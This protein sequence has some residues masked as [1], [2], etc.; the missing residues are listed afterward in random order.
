MVAA[1]RLDWTEAYDDDLIP[2]LVSWA[3]ACVLGAA[4]LAVVAFTPVVIPPAQLPAV[5]SPLGVIFEPLSRSTTPNPGQPTRHVQGKA[6]QSPSQV[7]KT[8]LA[9]AGIFATGGAEHAL[10]Q[11]T[12]MIPGVTAVQGDVGA[13]AAGGKA[14]VE[15][16]GSEATPGMSQLGRT[17]AGGNLGHVQ[18][19]A[20]IAHVPVKVRALPIVAAPAL[21]NNAVADVTAMGSFVRARVAQ[22]QS[23]YERNGAGDLAGVVA[24]RLTI[25][26]AGIVRSA[27][28]VRRTWS[29][30]GAA[31][32]EQCMVDVARGWRM[33]FAGAGATVT[34]PVSFTRGT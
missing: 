18:G 8:T 32:T 23:C 4:W 33:P 26:D 27:E 12:R 20:S 34:I 22:L 5:A 31:A 21:G 19:G 10:E 30:P 14:S 24:L 25:G 2:R 15:A 9:L 7:V 29:G 17:D 28:I 16:R 3:I 13:H 11:I 1:L 6:A